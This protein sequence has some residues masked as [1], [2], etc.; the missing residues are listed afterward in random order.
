MEER[1]AEPRAEV[2]L[3]IQYRTSQEFLAAYTKNISG[4]G[5]FVR[6]SQPLPLNQIV[7]LRFSLPG[8]DRRFQIGGLVVW[9]NTSSQSAFPTGMGIKFQDIKREDAAA[10]SAF[11][12]SRGREISL[13]ETKAESKSASEKPSSSSGETPAN[14]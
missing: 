11:V 1:R 6:T 3:E 9:V 13:R 4:G 14:G 8:F 2:E 7:E 10:I 12:K 5:V